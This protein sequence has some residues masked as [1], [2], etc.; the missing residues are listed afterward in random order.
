MIALIDGDVIAYMSAFAAQRTIYY[1][2]ESADGE[3]IERHEF[4]SKKE[5]DDCLTYLE[6]KYKDD[7]SITLLLHNEVIAAPKKQ[8]EFFADQLLKAILR[9]TR[10]EDYKLFLTADDKS[11]FRYKVAKT[12][13]YKGNRKD[14]VKP[15]HYSHIRNYLHIIWEAYVVFGDEADDYLGIHQV[16]KMREFD[17]D[18]NYWDQPAH[19]NKSIICS[20]D[21][22]L[23]MIPGWHYNI[24]T[25]EKSFVEREEGMRFFWKQ[26]LMGDPVD[27]IQGV[28]KIGKM[29]AA[30]LI[31]SCKSLEACK[32]TV[33]M[34]YEKY[35]G[36]EWKEKYLEMGNLLWIKR[37][38][39]QM[40][41]DLSLC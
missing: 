7:Q 37:D 13:P 16:Q 9:E 18:S 11:N 41:E 24:K 15:V 1:V 34:T 33:K 25:G 21:K 14:L 38:I 28:P 30:D 32:E 17:P 31:D 8:A 10:A 26:M 29:K 20:I 19:N 36:L 35:Y 2:D 6:S 27:N 3:F 5:A 12:K 22:D 23:R 4:T 40:F 39:N